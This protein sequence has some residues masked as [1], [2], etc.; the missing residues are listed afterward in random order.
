MLDVKEIWPQ[1]LVKSDTQAKR[2]MKLLSIGKL[3]VLNDVH[4]LAVTLKRRI[5]C[6]KP[7]SRNG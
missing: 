5:E 7:S 6:S 3:A 4:M 2:G 1:P